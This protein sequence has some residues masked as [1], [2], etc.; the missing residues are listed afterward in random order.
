MATVFDF[1]PK[2]SLPVFA[3]EA[4]GGSVDWWPP[5]GAASLD[6]GR[7]RFK[8]FA[9]WAQNRPMDEAIDALE[10][11]L[12]DMFGK[13]GALEAGF[14]AAMSEAAFDGYRQPGAKERLAPFIDK[15][16]RSGYWIPV[17]NHLNHVAAIL[18]VQRGR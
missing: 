10:A 5:R 9:A 11:I 16:A 1:V 12:R 8:E 2:G 4:P 18:G 15:P 7:E 17:E 14:L 13:A 6:A 3:R